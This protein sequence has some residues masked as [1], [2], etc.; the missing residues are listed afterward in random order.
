MADCNI[1]VDFLGTNEVVS[2]DDGKIV[3]IGGKDCPYIRQRTQPDGT[4]VYIFQGPDTLDLG[5]SSIASNVKNA[6]ALLEDEIRE[7][8]E[9]PKNAKCN[10][11]I[12]FW[13]HSRGGVAATRV[14]QKLKKLYIN[15]FKSENCGNVKFKLYVADPYAGP[16]HTGKN[17]SI[18][19]KV[20]TKGKNT[21]KD[22]NE[23]N[24]AT[25]FYSMGTQFPCSPQKI[26]N[27]KTIVVCEAGHNQ[28]SSHMYNK[29]DGKELKEG[30]VYLLHSNGDLE[31]V[32]SANLKET[33]E[34]I[35]SWQK[36]Y[37]ARTRVL[38]EVIV[39]KLGL[40]IDYILDTKAIKEWQPALDKT[41]KNVKESMF[42]RT[43]FNYVLRLFS[44]KL[45]GS[46]IK[47]DG[48]FFKNIKDA[49]AA[50]VGLFN[51]DYEKA[52]N[53]LKTITQESKQHYKISLA[54]ALIER[55]KRYYNLNDEKLE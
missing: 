28:T 48:K 5:N 46:Y 17:V 36:S 42:L 4:T 50:V 13:G 33:I 6:V 51:N 44:N 31:K 52:L 23:D 11:L 1:K 53:S 27:A 32:T 26:M 3:K 47:K 37:S 45:F 22:K 7:W 19:L 15:K 35:C 8:I 55:V 16:T 25:V 49:K 2:S 38:T 24:D 41:L 18:D 29:A 34:T 21:D 39:K 30:G 20:N 10:M 12:T 43:A 40:K 9:K 14:C 54:N